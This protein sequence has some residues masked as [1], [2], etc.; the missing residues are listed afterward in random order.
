[1]NRIFARRC[2]GVSLVLLAAVCAGCGYGEFEN[3]LQNREAGSQRAAV[4][5]EMQ[6]AAP[7]GSTLVRIRVPN[8]FGTP[9]PPDADE[10]RREVHNVN[11]PG[12]QQTYEF[13]VKDADEGQMMYYCYLGAAEINTLNTADPNGSIRTFLQVTFPT[14][15]WRDIQWKQSPVQRPDGTPVHWET[16]RC[17][18]QQEFFYRDADQRESYRPMNGSFEVYTMNRDGYFAM[19]AWR[20]PEGLESFAEVNKWREAILGSVSWD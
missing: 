9:L 13:S 20:I 16:L 11:L 7:I 6:P 2:S 18:G 17:E 12:L 19:V 14:Q 8:N 5:R 10:R 3:R 4:M 15:S 1:M